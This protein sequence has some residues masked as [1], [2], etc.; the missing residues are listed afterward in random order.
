LRPGAFNTWSSHVDTEESARRILLRHEVERMAVSTANVEHIDTVQEALFQTVH[1]RQ[2][3]IQQ[4]CIE[5][6][7]V[8][9][10]SLIEKSGVSRVRD[11]TALPE[12]RNH[13]FLNLPKVAYKTH[14][15]C[16]VRQASLTAD[17]NGMLRRQSVLPNTVVFDNMAYDH[18]GKPLADIPLVQA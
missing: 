15:T 6:C 5:P 4:V 2:G 12:R 16:H 1:K 8:V 11:P 7:C 3:H 13:V 14:P 10:R 9:A 18:R 17:R